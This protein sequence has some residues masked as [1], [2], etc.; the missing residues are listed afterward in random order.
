MKLKE[1][2]RSRVIPTSK[3]QLMPDFVRQAKEFGLYP[4]KTGIR[5]GS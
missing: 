4:N 2:G 3:G 1:K 5:I